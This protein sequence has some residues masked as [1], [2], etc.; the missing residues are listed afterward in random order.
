MVSFAGDIQTLPFND[1]LWINQVKLISG[2]Q[3]PY[4]TL[5]HVWGAW[6]PVET[7]VIN[8]YTARIR[9][10]IVRNT[11][12]P[13]NEWVTEKRN[14]VEDFRRAFGE[15]AGRI[16]AV[17]VFTDGDATGARAH[18]YYGDLTFLTPGEAPAQA[19]QR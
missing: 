13:L 1:R 15:E 19:G 5:E 7:V 10:I 3:I 16:I 6:A 4:A 17:A 9:A 12:Q 2:I 11:P 14:V 8:S 18:G